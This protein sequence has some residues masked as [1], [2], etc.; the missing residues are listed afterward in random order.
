MGEGRKYD[1]G[2]IRWSLTP[3]AAVREIVKHLNEVAAGQASY[4]NAHWAWIDRGT[5]K[6]RRDAIY[7][8]L[9]WESD[10]GGTRSN[11]VRHLAIAGSCVLYLLVIAL[12]REDSSRCDINGFPR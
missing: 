10:E 5:V 12:M 9:A 2:K 1:K 3:W 6:L 4:E 7:N 11:S 8:L